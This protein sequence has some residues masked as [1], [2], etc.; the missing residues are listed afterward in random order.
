MT[1]FVA[2]TII[3]IKL[4]A[5]QANQQIIVYENQ[6]LVSALSAKDGR[7]KAREI[8]LEACVDDPSFTLNGQPAR[9][10]FVGVRKIVAISNPL[11]RDLDQEP[12][13]H[14][15]ELSYS[16]YLLKNR[17]DLELLVQGEQ[18]DLRYVE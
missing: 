15:T 12:P 18:V 6:Y 4:L 8:A 16:E 3:E 7:A 14:G 17:S 2:S 11:D 5:A 9:M 1:W 13:G 10:S